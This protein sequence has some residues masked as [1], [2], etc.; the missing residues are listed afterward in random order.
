MFVTKG[1]RLREVGAYEHKDRC[2]RGRHIGEGKRKGE[3]RKGKKR[4]G[5]R[6]RERG[7]EKS[8]RGKRVV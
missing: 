5:K 1:R 8:E 4:E 6:A 2:V 7:R 3:R